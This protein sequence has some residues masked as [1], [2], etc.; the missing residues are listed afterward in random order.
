MTSMPEIQI[1]EM[2]DSVDDKAEDDPPFDDHLRNLKA[3]TEKLRLET[4]RPSYLEWKAQLE[5]PAWKSHSKPPER[6][7]GRQEKKPTEEN[8]SLR[9]VQVYINGSS[10]RQ[11]ILL[12]PEK[13]CGF[14]NIDEA[15]NWLRKELVMIPIKENVC[16]SRLKCRVLVAH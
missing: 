7:M 2:L 13:V 4:R 14:G 1:E 6:D 10:S 8:I 5:G 16:S 11:P 3:L 12:A 15:L 9:D